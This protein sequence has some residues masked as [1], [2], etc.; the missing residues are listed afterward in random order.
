M[1]MQNANQ[2]ILPRPFGLRMISRASRE[3]MPF[4]KPV[5]RP[6]ITFEGMPFRITF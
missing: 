5:F 3:D 4:G 6:R 2:S 1:K